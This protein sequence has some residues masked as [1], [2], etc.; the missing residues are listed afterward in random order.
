MHAGNW[1]REYSAQ[2]LRRAWALGDSRNIRIR[3]R[4]A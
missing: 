3:L 4:S 1:S 2:R